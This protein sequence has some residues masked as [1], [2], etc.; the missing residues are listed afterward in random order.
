[1][2]AAGDGEEFGGERHRNT[3]APVDGVAQALDHI[4]LGLD[5]DLQWSASC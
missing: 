1:V 3:I 5:L 4:F 2:D